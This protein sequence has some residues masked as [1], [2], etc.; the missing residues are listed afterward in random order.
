MLLLQT[1]QEP[2]LAAAREK[3]EQNQTQPVVINPGKYVLTWIV[4]DE[5]TLFSSL[6]A[7]GSLCQAPHCSERVALLAVELLRTA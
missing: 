2:S 6:Q 7:P 5:V 1:G 4:Q 3:D